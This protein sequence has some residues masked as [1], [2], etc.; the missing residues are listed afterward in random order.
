MDSHQIIKQ[1]GLKNKTTEK[2]MYSKIKES[3]SMKLLE[4]LVSKYN[5]TTY[6]FSFIKKLLF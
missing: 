4:K 5:L 3:M 2:I 1:K 6:L